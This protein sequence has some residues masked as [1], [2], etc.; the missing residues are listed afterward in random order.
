M[1]GTLACGVVVALLPMSML[2]WWLKANPGTPASVVG[3]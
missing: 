2:I 1:T 3:P